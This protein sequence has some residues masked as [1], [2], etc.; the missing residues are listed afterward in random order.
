MASVCISA[1]ALSLLTHSC[2]SRASIAC[3][4]KISPEAELRVKVL[5]SSSLGQMTADAKC[6]EPR[7]RCFLCGC[8]WGS[9]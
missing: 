3:S 4:L 1:T 8:C 7:G 2:R 6:T 5:E 9:I